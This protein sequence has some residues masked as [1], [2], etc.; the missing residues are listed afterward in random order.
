MSL[1]IVVTGPEC[2]GKTTLCTSLAQRYKAKMIPEF[3]REYLKNIGTNYN[4]QDVLMIGKTQSGLNTKGSFGQNICFCDTDVLSSLIWMEEKFLNY[5]SGL[6]QNWLQNLPDFYLLCY[7]DLSW[8]FDP[9]RE[10]PMDRERLFKLYLKKIVQFRV[11]YGII[12]G[13]GS[14]RTKHAEFIIHTGF[15]NLIN[16]TA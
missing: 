13:V 14:I 2:S 1:K 3:S 12:Y 7:P 5:Q 8:E 10:N 9:L 6:Q 4:S 15:P 11:P 16:F